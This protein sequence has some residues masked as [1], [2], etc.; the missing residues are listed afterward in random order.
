[1]KAMSIAEY[2]EKYGDRPAVQE[3][4]I[5]LTETE[6]PD[7]LL[8]KREPH[9]HK[10]SY[11]RALLIA[12]SRGYS[13]APVLAA[14]ACERS[15]AGLTSLMI[16]E[17]IY[18][19]AASRCDGTVVTPLPAAENGDI[20]LQA[21]TRVLSALKSADACA[22]G[23]GLGPGPE[24][25]ELVK[26]VVRSAEC[27]LILDADALTACVEE[28]NL[29]ETCRAPLLVTPHEG[30]F[31]RMGGDL[32][33]G[34]LSGALRFALEHPGVL[35]ILKG[36]GTLVCQGET[37]SVNPTGSP[38]MAKGGSGDVLCGI[39]C[40]LLAQ[41]FDPS[42]AAKCAAWLHGAAGDRAAEE[43]GEYSMTPSDIIRALPQVFRSL[44][45][46]GNKGA[47]RQ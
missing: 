25:R 20:S 7:F 1:M 41:G 36:F 27:P 34:R 26:L 18:E 2:A 29:L 5:R 19:I 10:Y 9:T 47:D 16:P 28:K 40:A 6:M 24:V 38:A 23:P 37:V 39:L 33:D 11:G 15:G 4:K 14:N 8:P 21:K 31:R 17:S 30:E 13:G 22:I 45:E 46:R 42:F 12:G 32:S 35:L 3:G 43:T 44:E